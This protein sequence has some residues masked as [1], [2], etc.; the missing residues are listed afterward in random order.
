MEEAEEKKRK[1]LGMERQGKPRP[2][3]TSS[4]PWYDGRN[5]LHNYT[6]IDTPRNGTLL[7]WDE[8]QKIVLRYGRLN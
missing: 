8:I 1:A 7:T 2:G 6:I 3:Y 5:S 4:D